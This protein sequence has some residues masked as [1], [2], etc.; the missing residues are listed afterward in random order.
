MKM[1]GARIFFLLAFVGN[2]A[3]WF[4]VGRGFNLFVAGFVLGA[5]IE[6]EIMHHEANE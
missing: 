1:I 2:F 6:A 4:L 5:W 3:L